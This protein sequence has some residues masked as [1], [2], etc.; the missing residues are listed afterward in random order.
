MV[1]LSIITVCYNIKDDIEKTCESIVNQSWQDF[2]WIVVD[3]GSTDGTLEILKK[4]Q[5]RINILISEKD[6]GIYNA[7]NKGI[8][9][10]SGKY[11]NF[12]NGGDSFYHNNIL[13]SIFD[14][15]EYLSDVLY[16][17]GY[18]KLNNPANNVSYAPQVL[19][20]DF[21][22]FRTIHHQSAFI[23]KDIF[24]KFGFYNESYKIVSDYEMWLILYNNNAS[25]EYLP[26]IVSEYTLGG[27]STNYLTRKLASSER[28]DVIL[29][30]FTD[31]E[32]KKYYKM[33]IEQIEFS[34][35]DKILS[36]KRCAM[37][38]SKVITIF[39]YSFIYLKK[40]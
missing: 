17:H 3:G 30:Y 38:N 9:L 26:Y 36:F 15:K 20:K 40:K 16:G 29:K 35:L 37:P 5:D 31:D 23:K 11:L 6:N 33:C 12:M 24:E 27:I 7:M 10:A 21:L 13:K 28:Q 39:G 22:F 25:F 4:Y 2:E 1:K 8:K 32:L 34:F 14:N 18:R 19:N